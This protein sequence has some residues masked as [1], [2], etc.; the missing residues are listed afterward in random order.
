MKIKVESKNGRMIYTR[1]GLSA[2]TKFAL[3][4]FGCGFVFAMIIATYLVMAV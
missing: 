4:S 2:D 1:C 3:Y